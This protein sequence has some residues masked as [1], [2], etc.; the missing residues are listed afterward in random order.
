MPARFTTD[1]EFND[2]FALWQLENH[3]PDWTAYKSEAAETVLRAK[4]FSI[5][6]QISISHFIIAFDALVGDGTLK[7][8][9]TPRPLAPVKELTVA[10]YRSIPAAVTVQKYRSDPEF[11]IQVDNLIAAGKI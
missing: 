1:Q 10:E 4:A 6:G 5:E 11:R 8:L 7:K 9:R 3:S 2:Q